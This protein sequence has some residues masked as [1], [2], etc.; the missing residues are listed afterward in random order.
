MTTAGLA[1]CWQLALNPHHLLLPAGLAGN[2]VGGRQR[3]ATGTWH[4]GYTRQRQNPVHQV[5]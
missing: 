1:A 2:D 3:T 5:S 4:H